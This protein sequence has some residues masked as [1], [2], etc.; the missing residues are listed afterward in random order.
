MYLGLSLRNN[1][2]TLKGVIASHRL[3]SGSDLEVNCLFPLELVGAAR[4]TCSVI[5]FYY[6]LSVTTSGRCFKTAILSVLNI[7][8]HT[9]HF[10]SRVFVPVRLLLYLCF[11][12]PSF[13]LIWCR[14]GS[15]HLLRAP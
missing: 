8:K 6:F 13:F 15:Q 2:S 14:S 5:S 10:L 12:F 4:L 7:P 1:T 3:F 11:S 9:K